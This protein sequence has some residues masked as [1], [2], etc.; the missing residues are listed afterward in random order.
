MRQR[1]LRSGR[2]GP[3]RER[4]GCIG[5]PSAVSQ[6]RLPVFIFPGEL[7]FQADDQRSHKQ[8]LTLYNP[9]GFTLRFKVLCM[10]PHRYTVLESEGCVRPQSCLD[11][12]VRHKDIGKCQ[13][14]IADWLRVEVCED[15][16]GKAS[17]RKNISAVV[18][19]TK[20]SRSPGVARDRPTGNTDAAH[21]RSVPV[22]RGRQIPL[23]LVTL[24]ILLGIACVILLTL[25]QVGQPSRLVPTYLHVTITQK[26]SAAYVL[27]LVTMVLLQG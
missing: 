23:A 15:G 11:I 3:E 13:F 26:V 9:Y 6:G 19:P 16:G 18:F 14:G 5:P 7:T 24:C 27:G 17:G 2:P 1:S 4:L 25:P 10:N 21:P 12:V 20:R 22:C 8:V